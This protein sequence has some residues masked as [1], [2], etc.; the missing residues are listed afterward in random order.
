MKI[1]PM[2]A[3]ADFVCTTCKGKLLIEDGPQQDGMMI[4]RYPC[5]SCRPQ[6]TFSF[7]L[8]PII[9]TIHEKDK[10]PTCGK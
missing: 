4:V 2:V 7:Y 5:D 6:G 9:P 1:E 8:Q 10:C 3:M